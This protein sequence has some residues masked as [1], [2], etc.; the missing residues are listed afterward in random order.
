MFHC[1]QDPVCLQT[2]LHL[3]VYGYHVDRVE[4]TCKFIDAL[5]K[6]GADPAKPDRSGE[7]APNMAVVKTR[8]V[9]VMSKVK[10][11]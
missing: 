7:T 11:T 5:L 9:Q 8:D 4:A 3:A 1:F 2:P 6:A 10:L